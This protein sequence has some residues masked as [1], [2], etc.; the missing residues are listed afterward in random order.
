MHDAGSGRDDAEVPERLLRPAEEGV[1]LAVALVL[2]LYV[3]QEGRLG[4]VLVH[5]YRVVDD[6]VGG[7]ERVDAGGVAAH[8]GHGIAHGGQV[9][10]ARHASEVL[11]DDAGRHERELVLARVGRVPGGEGPDV[12]GVYQAGARGGVP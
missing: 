9:D 3:D 5:L 12:V 6:Q 1:A 4:P 7:N 11:E 2:A 8:L 10:D